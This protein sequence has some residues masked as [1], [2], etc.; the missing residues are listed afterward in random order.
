MPLQIKKKHNNDKPWITDSFRAM[1]QKR[2]W[3]HS[4]GNTDLFR[5]YKARVRNASK[6]LRKKFYRTKVSDLKVSKPRQWWKQTKQILGLKRQDDASLKILA[7]NTTNGDL[8]ALASEINKF[9]QSVTSHLPPLDMSALP[10]PTDTVP[11]KYIISRERVEKKLS[12]ID[13]HKSPG[14][15]SIPNW[16]LKDLLGSLSGPICA[17]Y[18]SSIRQ[19]VFPT[20]WKS[21]NV[22]SL[23]KV[24]PPCDIKSDLRPISLTPVLSKILESFVGEW[25]WEIVG[26][27][28]HKDQFGGIK[29]SSTTHA[30]VDMLHYWHTAAEKQN[31]TRVLLLDYSKAFD[32]VDHNILIQKLQHYGV[33]DLLL[34]WLG[35]FLSNRQQR[36]RIGQEVSEWLQMNGSVP[37]GSWLGPFLFVVMINDLDIPHNSNNTHIHKYMDDSSVSEE[38][39]SPNESTL[40]QTTDHIADWSDE[41]NTRLNAVKTKEMV[42]SFKK[43]TLDI[44]YLKLMDKVLKE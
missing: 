16:I 1:I 32:L 43:K 34:R 2:Q 42:I 38:I 10:P 22:V 31:I 44:P 29:G 26:P 21:A 33:P 41:N 5:F 23:P 27:H 8:Q 14:P 40:Q 36:V 25:L 4:N 24:N 28:I 9:N 15:D 37:Q 18:N 17:I 20:M 35:S 6:F 39:K 13:I 3:A 12:E 19:G 30:L 7:A 11:E